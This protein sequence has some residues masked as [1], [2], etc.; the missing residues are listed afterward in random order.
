MEERFIYCG[1]K[2]MR[3]GY[4]TGSCAAAAAKAAAEA[5]LTGQKVKYADIL[6]P[7]GER[8]RLEI[9]DC[10]INGKTAAC[11]VIKDSGDDPDITNGIEI[12]AEVSLIDSG[13]EIIGGK[14]VGT[15]TKAG[16]DQPVGAAAI[17]SVPRKMIAQSVND[18]AEMQEYRG[19]FRVVISV[20]KG[21]ELAK[22]TFNPRI[23]ILGGISIIGTTG[24]VEPMSS[25]ALIE[26]IR[27]EANIRRKEGRSV[28][29]LTVGNYS[30]RFV[31]EKL[32][33]LSEQCVMCSNFIGD[34]IDIGITLGFKNILIYGHIG[35]LVKLGSGIMNTHSSYADGRM[36][37]LIACGAL[38]GLDNN[39]LCRLSDCAT[40][41]AALDILYE[42]GQEQK[43]LDILTE[44]IHGYL[45]ARAKGEAKV[46]A[47]IFSY[48]H[49][50]LLKT[51]Y[52][53]EI[54]DLAVK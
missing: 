5:L 2:K 12:T 46:G 27:T 36:E 22:K 31:S 53:D 23:G 17:N 33:Q 44:R 51:Q 3:C 20:P 35:K 54:L 15:V 38:A 7:K 4:T 9:S 18:A 30:E 10:T 28:L 49:D 24:I 11:T 45:Q 13:V 47:V 48:Q 34:A 29:V 1:T 26:T 21:E 52:T 50:M 32:P 42:S 41:D 40:T 37:T 6:L 14:G 43:L 39:L 19:G 16:L 8:L 25:S